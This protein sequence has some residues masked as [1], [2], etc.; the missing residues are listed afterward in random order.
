MSAD[1]EGLVQ[2][3]IRVLM[4]AGLAVSVVSSLLLFLRLPVE[5]V[6]LIG[7]G[8]A[9]TAIG[10]DM[11]GQALF[12]HWKRDWWKPPPGKLATVR[13]GRLSSVGDGIFTGGLGLEFLGYDWLPEPVKLLVFGAAV[14]GF[15]LIWVGG[16]L[17]KRRAVSPENSIGTTNGKGTTEGGSSP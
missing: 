15:G 8:V 14:T 10:L 2:K 7:G 11:F 3:V 17:D 5:R 6:A 9:F 12:P 16:S 4:A 1:K 13:C